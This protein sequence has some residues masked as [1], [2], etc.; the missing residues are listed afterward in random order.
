M[1]SQ[2]FRR[3]L[4]FTLAQEG[5]YVHD[6][7]D[8]GGE[9]KFGISKRAYPDLDI[10]QLSRSD[11]AAIYHRDYWMPL[12]GDDLPPL[13]A[14]ILFDWAVHSGVQMASH[15]LQKQLGGLAVDGAIGP[16]TVTRARQVA[17]THKADKALAH[18]LLDRRVRF[19]CRLVQREPKR[20][21]FL[22]GWMRRTHDLCALIT[23]GYG[24]TMC[25][26]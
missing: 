6:P 24:E 10:S 23:E 22:L 8:P 17:G 16:L 4:D 9:T 11:A 13:A 5:G 15:A 19:L 21:R 18:A 25:G 3:A 20:A 2:A 1:A 7:A 12:R 26:L 14:L